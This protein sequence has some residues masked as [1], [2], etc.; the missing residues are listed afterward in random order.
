MITTNEWG[1]NM[2]FAMGFMPK[3]PTQKRVENATLYVIQTMISI[4][5]AI[6]IFAQFIGNIKRGIGQLHFL[7]ILNFF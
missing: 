5:H 3:A 4:A 1:S 7:K 2:F 6:K